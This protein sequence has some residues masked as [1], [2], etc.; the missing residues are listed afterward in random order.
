[1]TPVT[2]SEGSNAV[3]L[4]FPHSSTHLPDD[5]SSDL[6]AN[7]HL[8]S[9]TDWHLQTLYADLLPDATRV[10]ANFHRYVIDANRDPSGQSLYPGQAT[11]GLVPDTDFDGLPIREAPITAPAQTRRLSDY[12]SAYHLALKGQLQRIRAEHGHAILYD[13]HSIRS[14]IPRLFDGTLPDLNIGTF[15]GASCDPSLTRGIAN[16]CESTRGFSSVHNGRFK[17][18]WTTRHYGQPEQGIHAIQMEIAQS[19]YLKTQSTPWEYDPLKAG[20]LR[21]VLQRIL[22]HLRDWRP[23]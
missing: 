18:G 5:M 10:E 8:L 3:V 15:D 14:R 12:H 2:V 9:D 20:S 6:N 7:G 21:H 1:M 22:E 17:G 11:T 19:T 4:A 23:T 13:C 16:I